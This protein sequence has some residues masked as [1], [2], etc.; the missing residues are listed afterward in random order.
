MGHDDQPLLNAG[1][2]EQ[3][4]DG[5]GGLSAV[6]KPLLGKFGINFDHAGLFGGI[7]ITEFLTMIILLIILNTCFIWHR[8]LTGASF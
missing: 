3:L 1:N 6:A 5:L 4:F 2:L 7:V 8:L